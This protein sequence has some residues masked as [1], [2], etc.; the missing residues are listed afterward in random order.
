M[1]TY[2]PRAA[3]VQQEWYLVDAAGKTLGRLASRIATLLRGKHRPNYTP[4]MDMGD[5]VIV[6]N[7]EKV[8]LTGDKR[9]QKVYYHHSGYF[10][11]LKRIPFERMIATHPERVIRLAVWGMLPHNR[12]GRA[13]LRKLKVYAGPQHPHDAQ[14]PKPIDL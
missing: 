9:H 5:Y 13:L 10:G 12:L 3:D 1:R 4:H 6:V 8:V 2:M 14:Q 7:A 11:G